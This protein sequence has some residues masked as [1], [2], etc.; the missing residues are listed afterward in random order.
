[1]FDKVLSMGHKGLLIIEEIFNRIFSPRFN[2]LYYLG[3]IAFFFLWFDF[4]SGIYL[5]FYY[6]ISVD[7][8]YKSI[9]YLTNNQWY[10][11]GIMRSIHRYSSD[12]LMIAM[13]LHLVREFLNNRFRSWRWVAWVT[14]VVLMV[15]F[16]VEGV[17]GYWMVWD[18][19]S[20]VIASI[21][22]KFLDF[23][24]IFGEPISRAFLSNSMVSNLLFIGIIFLHLS[25]P[26]LILIAAWIHLVRISRPVIHP[27]AALNKTIGILLI[28]V[29]IIIP[30]TSQIPA[31]LNIAAAR[32]GI[33]WLYLPAYPMIAALPVWY[34][35][36]FAGIG[37]L[38][39]TFLP[40][41]IRT[42]KLPK[43]EVRLETCNGCEL[44]FK[45]CPYEAIYVR[46]RS[47]GRPYEFEAVVAEKKCASCGLCIGACDFHAIASTEPKILAVVCG[48]GV[49]MKGLIDPET[50]ALKDMPN[51]RVMILPCVAMLQPI[52]MEHAF[53][54]GA[55]G[56]FIA[57]CEVND[58]HY[59]E[60]NRW[61]EQRILNVRPPVLK[62]KT[63]DIDKVRVVWLS[64]IH[65]KDFF[66]TLKDFNNE[67]TTKKGSGK[68]IRQRF[69]KDR[70]TPMG[71]SILTLAAA[72]TVYL[73]DVPYTFFK[74]RDSL[75][76]FSFKHSGKP[77]KVKAALS[78][79]ELE[80]LPRH[81][82]PK[83]EIVLRR[84]P[85]YAEVQID[86]KIVMAKSFRPAGLWQ[87]GSSFV[88]EN[89][90]VEPGMHN[91]VIKL[92]ESNN[93]NK[94]DVIYEDTIDFKPGARIAF[95]F[96]EKGQRFV[97]AE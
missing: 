81:M 36:L 57:G 70:L 54:S 9:E 10:L 12:G 48:Y 28:A 41:L 35:W 65:T 27:P 45:D 78:N 46:K 90:I 29:C 83:S 44:C 96:D 72:I 50:R 24:P 58:C 94:F 66:T 67:L 18:Q 37:T 16:W 11:G 52:M 53:K 7:E 1:M 25:I 21:T 33:D 60:G 17:T 14:G 61:L 76:V 77:S 56:M 20:Q 6:R 92:S 23:L 26:T 51:C 55:D 59:R 73:S 43:A 85:V 68:I 93:P 8:A 80:K 62:K 42:K 2:P 34:S 5:L 15:T 84:F 79:E 91:V 30:A 82:R 89:I 75:M 22:V 49:Q 47:D 32:F 97:I 64:K 31:D 4:V 86:N 39:L 71:I 38:V 13:L 88:F 19:R 63:V 3:A 40:W 87:N 95:D 74:E 69:I